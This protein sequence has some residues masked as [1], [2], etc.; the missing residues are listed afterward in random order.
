[1]LAPVEGG[2][3][4]VGRRRRRAPAARTRRRRNRGSRRRRVN[5]AAAARAG[6]REARTVLGVDHH[7]RRLDRPPRARASATA[8]GRA[9]VLLSELALERGSG[10]PGRSGGARSRP[11]GGRRSRVLGVDASRDRGA[12][13]VLSDDSPGEGPV[14]EQVHAERVAARLELHAV[15]LV[16]V[17][18]Q[19]PVGGAG[20]GAA[21]GR[22]F[23]GSFL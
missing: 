3:G 7:D 23:E 10:R 11:R 22:L 13:R 14:P 4:R 2:G 12:H 16:R 17:A 18:G 6:A 20:R 15:H 9:Y 5:T 1:M 19:R 21:P 8:R